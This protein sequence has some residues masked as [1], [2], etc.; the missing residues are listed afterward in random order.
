MYSA[1]FWRHGLVLLFRK[2]IRKNPHV[3]ISP[4]VW[5]DL[6]L[7]I[8]WYF[9]RWFATL[10]GHK[11]TD[12]HD[13]Y[14]RHDIYKR[15]PP[16][17]FAAG[18]LLTHGWSRTWFPEPW[19]GARENMPFK[20]PLDILISSS[21]D[22]ICGCVW[23]GTDLEIGYL[24]DS[25]SFLILIF[26]SLNHSGESI[27]TASNFAVH[28]LSTLPGHFQLLRHHF[29]LCSK[30]IFSIYIVWSS[31]ILLFCFFKWT[32]IFR[33]YYLSLWS[34]RSQMTWVLDSGRE[35]EMPLCRQKVIYF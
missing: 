15:M 18:V 30:L 20:F 17:R 32:F 35:T 4:H 7:T 31:F 34:L 6:G 27:L 23:C 28:S 25:S 29:Q 21:Y 5:N 10:R 19:D 24:L 13:F 12:L 26:S 22:W 9:Y 16:S 33:W 14:E 2:M 3:R 8:S 1:S 11:I